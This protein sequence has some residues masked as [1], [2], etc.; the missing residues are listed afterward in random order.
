[1]PDFVTSEPASV[2]P[3]ELAPA[4][5]LQAL[6]AGLPAHGGPEAPPPTVM[7]GLS[8]LFSRLAQPHPDSIPGGAAPI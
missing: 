8:E 2:T 1:M 5:V 6:R 3:P 4:Q 7:G